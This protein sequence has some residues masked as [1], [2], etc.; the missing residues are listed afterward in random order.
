MIKIKKMNIYHL[1][2]KVKNE[3]CEGATYGTEVG[4]L[5]SSSLE[6]IPPKPTLPN[7]QHTFDMKK[8]IVF[9]LETTGL[10]MLGS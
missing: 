9:D 7:V 2:Q 10:G 1:F 3:A 5:G 4:V 6:T 8:P